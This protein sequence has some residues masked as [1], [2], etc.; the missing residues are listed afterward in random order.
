M[1]LQSNLIYIC[2][3]ASSG[4]FLHMFWE[5]PVVISLWTHVHLV[6]SSLLQIDWSVNPSLCLLNDDSGLCISSLQ[7]RMLF[8]GFTAAKK[9]IIQNWFT[10]HMCRKTYWIRSLLQIVSC[11]CTT[12]QVGGARPSTIDAWQCFLFD[13]RDCIKEWLVLCFYC[14]S[15]SPSLL[16]WLW[17][18]EYMSV[19]LFCYILDVMLC[20]VMLCYVMLCYVWKKRKNVDNKKKKMAPLCSDA[21]QVAPLRLCFYLLFYLLLLSLFTHIKSALITYDKGTILDI[22]QRYTNLFQVTLSTNS[23]SPLEILRNAEENNGHRQR[24]KKHRGKR[25]GIRNRLRKGAHSPPLPSIL[26]TNVQSMENKMDD[27][28]ARISFQWDI[29]DCNI[30]CLSETWLTPSVPDTAVT[31]SDNFSVLRMDRTA[32]AGK[33]KGGG[34]CFMINKNWCDP[35]NISSLSRSCSPHLEHLSIICR[36]FYLPREFSSIIVTAVYIPPQADTGLALSKLHDVLSGYI[37]KHPDAA[38]I[39]AGDFNKANLRQVMPNFHQHVSCPTRGPNTLD[40]CYSQFKNA[41]KARSLPAFG[42]SDHAAIL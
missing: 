11:E 27:L 37:N 23:S 38:F 24:I 26:L 3:T 21:V 40:H 6:L 31:P 22:G 36:P 39:I 12:A 4:T 1:K 34:V 42:K 17:A 32:E 10:P 30:I 28:R 8:A 35:R 18:I 13:I 16:T 25:A 5:C 7:K 9:T 15:L 29:R 14:P 19:V 41:Y 2:N 33:S 20:Y